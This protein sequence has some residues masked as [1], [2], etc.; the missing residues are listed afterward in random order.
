MAY[1]REDL[2][3]RVPGPKAKSELVFRESYHWVLYVQSSREEVL[4]K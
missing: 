4:V 2:F 1:I 3:S